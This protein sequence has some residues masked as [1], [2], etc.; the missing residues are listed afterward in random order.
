MEIEYKYPI[1]KGYKVYGIDYCRATRKICKWYL[2]PAYAIV[3]Y[4]KWLKY[5][6]YKKLNE[7]NIMHTEEGCSMT[8]WDI[9]E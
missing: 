4:L 8:L 9:L 2:Y 6:I 1:P 7:I 3:E 5:S